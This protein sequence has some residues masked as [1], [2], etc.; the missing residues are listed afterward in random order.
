LRVGEGLEGLRPGE[1]AGP[2]QA[3]PGLDPVLDR[4]IRR[5]WE[6]GY[7]TVL[8]RFPPGVHRHRTLESKNALQETWADANFAAYQDRLKRMMAE[9]DERAR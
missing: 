1:P 4:A 6:L 7:R 9:L 5:V 2:A 3:S 8:P